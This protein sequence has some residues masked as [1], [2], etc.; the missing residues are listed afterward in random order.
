MSAIPLPDPYYEKQRVRLTYKPIAE[1]DYSVDLPSM[2][3][4]SAGHFV[5]C[6]NAEEE[7]YKQQ[8]KKRLSK[9]ESDGGEK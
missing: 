1:H 3:E 5:Y 9:A 7:R 8:I 2:R 6:N 4:I